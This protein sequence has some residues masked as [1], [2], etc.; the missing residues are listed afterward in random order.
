MY[1]R[2]LKI[3]WST[4]I[5]NGQFLN[6]KLPNLKYYHS[7]VKNFY[8]VLK[9]KPEATQAEVKEA[10]YTLSKQYHP[11]LASGN[12]QLFKAIGEAYATLGN[13]EK[14]REYDESMFLS[15]RSRQTRQYPYNQPPGSGP[16]D[17][18]RGQGPPPPGYGPPP[19]G[20][21]NEFEEWLNARHRPPR[22]GSQNP[23]DARR[24]AQDDL[25]KAYNTWTFKTRTYNTPSP[26][27][28]PY[29]R[30]ALLFLNLYA[31][32]VMF[33]M[34]SNPRYDS[35]EDYYPPEARKKKDD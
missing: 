8:N 23:E 13:V 12:E 11:D 27:Q 7:N 16:W 6:L 30:I 26:R 33:S 35:P 3:P 32:S 14:R 24:R 1:N 29:I 2:L 10:Y 17:A 19:P 20:S 18:Y 5:Q 25:K 21:F 34:I 4:T 22:R 28:N 15:E 31:L 9:I